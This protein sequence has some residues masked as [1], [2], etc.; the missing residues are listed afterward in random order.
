[1]W[2]PYT[3]QVRARRCAAVLVSNQ[4]CVRFPD[5]IG[6]VAGFQVFAWYIVCSVNHNIFMGLYIPGV[7]FNGPVI[8]L[9]GRFER[10]RMLCFTV[11]QLG[12]FR[13]GPLFSEEEPSLLP[14]SPAA[15]RF[16]L[17]SP[18]NR[19]KADYI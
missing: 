8:T 19:G 6:A 4:P 13:Q 10:V 11:Y 9:C 3:D 2:L 17:L 7:F 12:I 18:R 1:M 14:S 15:S 5:N 16:P